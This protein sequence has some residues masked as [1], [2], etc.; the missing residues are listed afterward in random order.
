MKL[1]LGIQGSPNERRG[2][3]I[4]KVYVKIRT[5]AGNENVEE[6]YKGQTFCQDLTHQLGREEILN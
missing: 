2:R 4:G 6:Q 1:K 3:L 5:Q